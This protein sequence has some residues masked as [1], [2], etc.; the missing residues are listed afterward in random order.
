[1]G[2]ANRR[3]AAQA[4]APCPCGTGKPSGECCFNGRSYHKAHSPTGL[5]ALPPATSVDKCYMKQ[6][7]SCD[8]G[9]SGEHLI[10]ASIMAVLADQG[11]FTIS[12][13][14][15]IPLG[16]SRAVGPNSL[17][18]NCLCRKHNS[19]LHPL[20]DAAL[21]FFTSLKLCLERKAADVK[22]IVSGHDLERWLLKTVKALAVSGNLAREQEK[23][24][25][26]FATDIHVIKMIDDPQSWSVGTGLYCLARQGEAMEN[27]NRFQLAP[28]TNDDGKIY[29]LWANILGIWF[30]LMLEPSDLLTTPQLASAVFRPNQIVVRD[31][32]S[33]SWLALSWEDSFPHTNSLFINHVRELRA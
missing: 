12:G 16:E 24:S 30:I 22:F 15:W 6:L 14:P 9:I 27:N 8:G 26:E 25:G 18:A 28:F 5:R 31:Q 1:V 33:T 19:C 13:L 2:E 17:R 3:K 32:I 21:K 23:L 10:S 29:G 4:Q 7:G 20:D 11:E